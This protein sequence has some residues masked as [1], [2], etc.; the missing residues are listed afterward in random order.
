MIMI[1]VQ[2]VALVGEVTF[3]SQ[4]AYPTKSRVCYGV[5]FHVLFLV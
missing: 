3:M 2:V 4:C 5:R 1:M